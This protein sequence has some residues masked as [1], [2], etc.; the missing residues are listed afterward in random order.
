MITTIDGAKHL[1]K[2]DDGH[3]FHEIFTDSHT[4]PT[5]SELLRRYG[6]IARG[7]ELVDDNSMEDEDEDEA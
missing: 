2:Y 1:W 5:W 3:D 6:R 4:E 7:W